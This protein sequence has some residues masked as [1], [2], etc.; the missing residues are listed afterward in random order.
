MPS[1]SLAPLLLKSG[2][3]LRNLTVTQRCGKAA[4]APVLNLLDLNLK[5]IY[6]M[7]CSIFYAYGHAGNSAIK[8][9]RK[10]KHT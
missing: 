7:L 4:K 3:G 2:K 9:L 1:T 8:A 5:H 6:V 10:L